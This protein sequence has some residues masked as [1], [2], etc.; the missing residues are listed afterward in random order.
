MLG[1]QYTPEQVVLVVN[2]GS[3]WTQLAPSPWSL[4]EVYSS[5]CPPAAQG[6]FLVV[7]LQPSLDQAEYHL[8]S[9]SFQGRTGS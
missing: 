3:S 2:I 1:P 8:P 7:A 9:R 5:S 4:G 6:N